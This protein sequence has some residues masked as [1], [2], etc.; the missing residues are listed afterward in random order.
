MKK[1]KFAPILLPI[2]VDSCSGSVGGQI[3][4][5]SSKECLEGVTTKLVLAKADFTF[6]TL[7]DFKDTA[8]WTLAIT[9]KT[10]I[11]LFDVYEVVDD[12]VEAVKYTSGS[13][14]RVTEKEVKKMSCESY[15]GLGSTKALK[16]YQ[17]LSHPLIFEI[18]D[19]GEAI[20]IYHSD[21]VQIKGQTMSEFDVSIRSRPTNEKPA[22][23]KQMVVFKDFEELET[24]GVIIKQAWD[25]QALQ[26]IFLLNL[27]IQGTPTSSEIKVK[28]FINYGE[29]TFD[30]V[31]F[32]DWTYSGGSITGSSVAGGI[33]TLVGTGLTAGNLSLAVT[34]ISDWQYEAA[35]VA[36]SI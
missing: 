5:G 36:V 35:I 13:Y 17:L 8:K 1:I 31:P 11:P 15:L 28:A 18:T 3:V 27:E 16:T 6:A 12:N 20:G 25:I 26:G 9:A 22:F 21:G 19:A 24:N 10:L 33:Y 7:A 14:S 34:V 4:T 23:V 2:F 29:D 32:A 30:L